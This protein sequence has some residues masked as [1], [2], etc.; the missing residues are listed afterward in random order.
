MENRTKGKEELKKLI[1]FPASQTGKRVGPLSEIS[2]SQPTATHLPAQEVSETEIEGIIDD[3]FRPRGHCS[4]RVILD[5]Y[6][7]LSMY[8]LAASWNFPWFSTDPLSQLSG[9]LLPSLLGCL[10]LYSGALRF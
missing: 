9:P 3:L 2:H 10:V 6:A 4:N 7:A 5:S 1:S 8:S